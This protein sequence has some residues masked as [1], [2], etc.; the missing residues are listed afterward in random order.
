MKIKLGNGL[1][2]I[3]LLVLGLVAVSLFVAASPIQMVLGLLFILLFPGYVTTAALF[4]RDTGIPLERLILSLGIS[5]MVAALIGMGLNYTDWG[6][7]LKSVLFGVGAY[8]IIVSVVAWLRLLQLPPAERLSLSIDLSSDFWNG[9]IFSR[10]VS[11]LVI[12]SIIAAVSTLFYTVANPKIGERFTELYILGVE[13]KAMN[14]PSEIVLVDGRVSE[15]QYDGITES[16]NEPFA[17]LKI[18][19]IN[20][21][22]ANTEYQ[23]QLVLD[24]AP[25]RFDVEGQT[26]DGYLTINL[27]DGEKW[28]KDISFSPTTTGANLKL[29]IILAVAG[30]PLFEDPPHIFLNIK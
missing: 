26:V 10:L 22:S 29:N 28:E 30:R 5:F 25:I 18:G 19:I 12:I 21:Q 4:P 6:I 2:P 11:A 7:T 20:H 8:V 16:K 3:N 17:R 15:V 9:N 23:L 24:E 27:G 1:I 14:Y 13:G